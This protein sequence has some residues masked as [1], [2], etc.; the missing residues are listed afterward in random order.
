M[1]KWLILGFLLLASCMGVPANVTVVDNVN[2]SQYIG[3]WYEIARLDHSFERGMDNV[4]AHYEMQKSGEIK[5]TNK[6]FNT[7]KKEWK[8]V[9]GKAYFI[10]PAHADGTLLGKLKVSFFGPFYGA[11]N[12]IALD[13]TLYNYVMICGPNKKYLWIMSRTPELTYP[14]K[15]ELVSQAKQ[16]GFATD[17]LIYVNQNPVRL[18]YKAGPHVN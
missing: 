2:A 16:L 7:T 18:D 17:D 14:I 9:V 5:V 6:G 15:Q 12:I 13:R 10:E 4:T 3:T 8:E 1:K 11:Y